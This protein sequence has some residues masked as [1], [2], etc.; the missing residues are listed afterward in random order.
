MPFEGRGRREF[1]ACEGRSLSNVP[2]EFEGEVA[3]AGAMA[4]ASD[5]ERSTT[6]ARTHRCGCDGGA[7]QQEISSSL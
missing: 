3:S 4:E 1:A 2:F 6:T 7:L 5:V